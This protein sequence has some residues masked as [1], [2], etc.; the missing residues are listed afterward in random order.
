MFV[1]HKRKQKALSG[2]NLLKAE[3]TEHLKKMKQTN[4]NNNYYLLY[5]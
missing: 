3:R 4:R 1:I 2:T 5:G